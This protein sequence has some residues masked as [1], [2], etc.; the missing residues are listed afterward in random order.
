[1]NLS[2]KELHTKVNRL[3]GVYNVKDV[4]QCSRY[5]T[6]W[7]K[8]F[9]RNES[10]ETA[11]TTQSGVKSLLAL[12]YLVYLRSATRLWHLIEITGSRLF[13]LN[14]LQK[15]DINEILNTVAYLNIIYAIQKQLQ[16]FECDNHYIICSSSV[17]LKL[18]LTIYQTCLLKYFT[19]TR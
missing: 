2:E 12:Y 11:P 6:S 1:M 7:T 16:K 18:P 4:V 9:C 13:W 3:T 19:E 5:F 14:M 17:V 15:Y 10:S 8:V